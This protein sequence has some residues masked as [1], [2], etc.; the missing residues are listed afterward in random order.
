MIYLDNAATTKICEKAVKAMEPYLKEE[1]GN[2]SGIYSIGRK[3]REQVEKVKMDKLTNT[4]TCKPEIFF[5][6]RGTESDE[7]GF[8]QRRILGNHIIT[9][10]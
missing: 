8:G 1:Y 9:S 5:Y 6:F 3:T 2:P 4:L 10:K 7:L